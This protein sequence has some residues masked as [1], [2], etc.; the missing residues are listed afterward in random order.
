MSAQ[1]QVGKTLKLCKNSYFEGTKPA[2]S[3][4]TTSSWENIKVM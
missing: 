3:V 1:P 4:S 2:K